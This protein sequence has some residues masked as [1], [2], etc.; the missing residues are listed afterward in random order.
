MAGVGDLESQVVAELDALMP[1]HPFADSLRLVARS[2]ARAMDTEGATPAGA[3]E[4][5]ATL[6][7]IGKGAGDGDAADAEIDELSSPI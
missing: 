1:D 3:R 7:E 2:L 5:R 4:L 6:A